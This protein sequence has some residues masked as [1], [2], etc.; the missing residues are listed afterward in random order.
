MNNQDFNPFG[1]EWKKEMLKHSKAQLI[2]LLKDALQHKTTGTGEPVKQP[3]T[4]SH[5]RN[6]PEIDKITLQ[7]EFT[8]LSAAIG[9]HKTVDEIA[10]IFW[11]CNK[12]IAT[13]VRKVTSD[14]VV[15]CE[16]CEKE[17]QLSVAR[18]DS[19]HAN[20]FCP[21]CWD[22]ATKDHLHK[23]QTALNLVAPYFADPSRC[24]Y[25]KDV[26]NCMY[27]A[28]NGNRCIAGS[29]MKDTEVDKFASDV[30]IGDVLLEIPQEQ[31]FLPEIAGMFDTHEWECLQFIHDDIAAKNTDEIE[32][33]IEELGLFTVEELETYSGSI[34]FINKMALDQISKRIVRDGMSASKIAMQEYTTLSQKENKDDFDMRQLALLKVVCEKL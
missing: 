21:T 15:I 27:L 9:G 12:K 32:C 17:T 28:P 30:P 8:N 5:Y 26:K 2:D 23:K 10:T 19:E 13:P 11:D 4:T 20:W 24:G 33:G 22:E 6:F 29:C 3:L 18:M 1:E 31:L 7:N 14:E 16:S 34:E 25:D